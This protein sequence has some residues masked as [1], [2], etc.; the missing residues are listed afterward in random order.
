[1]K[2]GEKYTV[3]E[4]FAGLDFS[5]SIDEVIEITKANFD[6]CET[7]LRVGRLKPV[8]PFSVAEVSPEPGGEDASPDILPDSPSPSRRSRRAS[9]SKE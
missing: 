6:A 4:S 7:L 5:A 9:R 3:L 8:D 1:M 2:I